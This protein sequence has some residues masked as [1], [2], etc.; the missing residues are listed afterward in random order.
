ML[1]IQVGYNFKNYF[2]EVVFAKLEG[3]EDALKDSKKSIEKIYTLLLLIRWYFLQKII[4]MIYNGWLE[5]K[6]S[7]IIIIQGEVYIISIILMKFIEYTRN[8]RRVIYGLYN[9]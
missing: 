1:I 2:S 7:A 3:K 8:K 9:C 4:F 5:K 6:D